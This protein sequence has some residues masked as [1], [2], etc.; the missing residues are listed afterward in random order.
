MKTIDLFSVR[1][2]RCAVHYRSQF[3]FIYS[4]MWIKNIISMHWY[5]W[6]WLDTTTK[7]QQNASTHHS[8][9]DALKLLG[10]FLKQKM[11]YDDRSPNDV[12][13]ICL[14]FVGLF[15]VLHS[16]YWPVRAL[17]MPNNDASPQPNNNNWTHTQR[18]LACILNCLNTIQ[19]KSI[20]CMQYYYIT[21]LCLE[22]NKVMKNRY[23]KEAL[24]SPIAE[25]HSYLRVVNLCM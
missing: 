4:W 13:G 18:K 21:N 24:C 11:I 15:V 16:F 12:V 2:L 6:Q 19:Y 1:E 14:S 3:T 7:K 9:V 17:G 25:T 22:N 5:S 20:C 8:H 23:E 10:L